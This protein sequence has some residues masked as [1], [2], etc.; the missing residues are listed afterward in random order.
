[1][2]GG[3]DSG[4]SGNEYSCGLGARIIFE[5]LTPYFTY[6]REE[7]NMIKKEGLIY[8]RKVERKKVNK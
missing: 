5:D 4:V 7:N 6:G 2:R 1:M 8:G 3:G